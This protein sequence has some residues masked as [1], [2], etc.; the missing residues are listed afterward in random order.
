MLPVVVVIA[1]ALVIVFFAKALLR[2]LNIPKAAVS[3]AK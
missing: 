2:K 3:R 1:A